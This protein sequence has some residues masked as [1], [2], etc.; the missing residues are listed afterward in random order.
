MLLVCEGMLI[1]KVDLGVLF[2]VGDDCFE[3]GDRDLLSDHSGEESEFD[4]EDWRDRDTVCSFGGAGC[5][6]G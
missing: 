5:R 2:G 3:A 1:L 6:E 4:A